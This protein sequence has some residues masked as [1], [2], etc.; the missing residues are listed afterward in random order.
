MTDGD[1]QTNA[2]RD[3]DMRKVRVALA[4]G[5]PEVRSAM[6]FLL[7][8]DEGVSVSSEAATAEELLERVKMSCPDVII[9]DCDLPGLRASELLPRLHSVCRGVQV[10]ALCSRPEMRGPALSAGADA[11]VCKTEPPETLVDAIRDRLGARPPSEESNGNLG[12]GCGSARHG[13]RGMPEMLRERSGGG[14]AM[15]YA[16]AAM[17]SHTRTWDEGV[18]SV[19]WGSRYAPERATVVVNGSGR[20]CWKDVKRISE[21]AARLINEHGASRILL[22]YTDADLDVGVVDVFGLPECYDR[23]GMPRNVRIALLVPR[24]RQPAGLYQ[25]YET[26]S[27]NKGYQCRLFGSRQAAEQWLES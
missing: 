2:H 3:A 12:R 11:F 27:R 19:P 17:V 26:V 6:R 24:A 7:E 1:R 23:A 18:V 9:L 13:T 16:S 14:R 25:F 5:R 20:L 15:K 10:V 21:E 4:D 22:D 8:H